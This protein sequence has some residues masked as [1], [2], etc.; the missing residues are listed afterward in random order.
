MSEYTPMSDVVLIVGAYV[1][2]M[3]GVVFCALKREDYSHVRD[4]IRELAETGSS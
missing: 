1:Y 3:G 4:S 2:L